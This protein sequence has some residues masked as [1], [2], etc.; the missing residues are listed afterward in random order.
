MLHLILIYNLDISITRAKT[1]IAIKKI[2][3]IMDA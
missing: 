1:P 2:G 3:N